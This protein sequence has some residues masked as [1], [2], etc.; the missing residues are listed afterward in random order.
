MWPMKAL[1]RNVLLAGGG[2]IGLAVVAVLAFFIF[3]NAMTPSCG[4]EP[5]SA[6]LSPDARQQV[7]VFEYDC[8]ATTDYSTHV[9]V[10]PAGVR[11]SN[12]PGNVIRLDTDGNV[13]PR[14]PGGGPLVIVRWID[15]DSLEISFDQRARIFLQNHTV[16]GFRI[17]YHHLVRHGA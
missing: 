11:L 4:A 17:G 6:T 14:G 7:V 2:L 16:R 5:I 9:S 10:L 12:Q 3:L 8:G 13:A 1:V 15:G